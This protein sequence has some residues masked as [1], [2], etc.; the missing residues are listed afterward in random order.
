MYQFEVSGMTCGHCA[1]TITDA[2]KGVDAAAVVT[3]NPASREVRVVSR[4]DAATV[5]RAIE[6]A[7]YPVLRQAAVL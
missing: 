6:D 4:L 7:G 5:A 3:A 2:V 1:A